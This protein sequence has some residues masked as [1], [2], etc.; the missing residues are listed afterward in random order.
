MTASSAPVRATTLAAAGRLHGGARRREAVENGG[1]EAK[2]FLERRHRFR[3]TPGGVERESE[4]HTDRRVP[5]RQARGLLERPRGLGRLAEGEQER[6]PEALPPGRA[7]RVEA[8]IL[9]EQLGQLVP[10]LEG[11][12]V[13]GQDGSNGGAALRADPEGQ[14]LAAGGGPLLPVLAL[15]EARRRPRGWRFAARE[16]GEDEE[17][18]DGD[19]PG[20]PGL[21][22]S[23]RV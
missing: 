9:A 18:R 5:G 21:P 4:A 6:Q 19:R 17:E 12:Q 3:R 20:H 14:G 16:R 22:R 8:D 7:G 13:P 2:R 15:A 10:A 1:V 23:R 11:H